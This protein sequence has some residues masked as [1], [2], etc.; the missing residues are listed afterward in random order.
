MNYNFTVY[1]NF[2][3]IGN[4]TIKVFTWIQMQW[5]VSNAQFTSLLNVWIG[6]MLLGI[7]TGFYIR[8]LDNMFWTV[9][10]PACSSLC[11]ACR[12]AFYGEACLLWIRWV[13]DWEHMCM[14]IYSK[15]LLV[16]ALKLFSWQPKSSCGASEGTLLWLTIIGSGGSRNF[17]RGFN[18]TKTS[19][20][21][22]LKSKKHI[23]KAILVPCDT[24]VA[25]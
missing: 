19:A 3:I 20:Q 1:I 24:I 13:Q 11:L 2:K 9:Y 25:I 16:H 7:T 8:K 15:C 14:Y 5:G 18:L 21:L 23:F 4:A 6:C 17:E 12:H 22:E 10:W